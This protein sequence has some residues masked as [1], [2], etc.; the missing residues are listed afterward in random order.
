MKIK[1]RVDIYFH[2]QYKRA[3]LNATLI[4]SEMTAAL[5]SSLDY[6]LCMKTVAS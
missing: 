2:V 5:E 4:I 3:S 1:Q 6:S